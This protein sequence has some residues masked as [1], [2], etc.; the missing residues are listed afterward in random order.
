MYTNTTNFCFWNYFG[1]KLSIQMRF[2]TW[3]VLTTRARGVL[4]DT[5]PS[6]RTCMHTV[7]VHAHTHIRHAEHR[8]SVCAC[9][10][11]AHVH[12]ERGLGLLYLHPAPVR[13]REARRAMKTV[14]G[15]AAIADRSEDTQ[16]KQATRA[17]GDAVEFSA[18]RDGS[19]PW[20][21]CGVLM[22]NDREGWG[23]GGGGGG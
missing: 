8:P 7:S 16:G 13:L 1:A 18:A 19:Y 2:K 14:W 22:A 23:G 15:E 11:C 6:A 4:A 17:P 20:R 10:T 12:S 21:H 3:Q 5:R 9:R